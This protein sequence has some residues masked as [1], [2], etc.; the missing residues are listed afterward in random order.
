VLFRDRLGQAIL[1]A[2][3]EEDSVALFLLD[4]DDFK[5]VNDRFGHH[6]G[7]L[8]LQE[9]A[10]R[11]KA[12]LRT[13]DTVARLGGD[14]F[15]ILLPALGDEAAAT[16]MARKVQGALAEP[17]EIE[18]HTIRISAS[19]GIALCPPHGYDSAGL[20]RA[21]DLAM[22]EAKKSSRGYAVATEAPSQRLLSS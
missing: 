6:T 18:S 17:F 10:R 16:R 21:A 4:L 14:E 11:L 13:V 19:V 20:L 3:R 5:I 2:E 9:V 7:D 15:A 22:Y 8:L 12:S 1:G